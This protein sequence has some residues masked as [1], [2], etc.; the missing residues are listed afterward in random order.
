MQRRECSLPGRSIY[1]CYYGRNWKSG[2]VSASERTQRKRWFA[3]LSSAT[4][5]STLSMHMTIW[6]RHSMICDPF[7]SG[8]TLDEWIPTSTTNSKPGTRPMRVCPEIK[9][10]SILLW[11]AILQHCLRTKVVKRLALLSKNTL[12][13]RL[14]SSSLVVMIRLRL[15]FA[16]C[17]YCFHVILQHYTSSV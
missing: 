14:N 11:K 7:V 17:I 2:S 10:S 4:L 13:A 9:P 6:Q 5:N 15:P 1:Q 3:N 12:W 8:T 16:T